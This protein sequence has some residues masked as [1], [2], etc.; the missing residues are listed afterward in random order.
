MRAYRKTPAQLSDLAARIVRGEIYIA[1]SGDGLKHS[2]GFIL[3]LAA[4]MKQRD[5][6]G[7]FARKRQ[8]DVQTIGAV[9]EE[10]HRALPRGINGYPMFMSCKFVHVNDVERLAEM[11]ARKQEALACA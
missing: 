7:R 6:R 9:Y 10:M 3:A 11:V 5:A 4:G 2:F 8:S 1:T